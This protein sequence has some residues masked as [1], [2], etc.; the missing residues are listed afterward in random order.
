MI[1]RLKT[2]R[3]RFALWVAGLLLVA[4]SAF[5]AY[6]YGSVANGL[7]A[8]MDASL[9]IDA[10]RVADG[11]DTVPNGTY[12]L[13]ERFMQQPGNAAWLE[14][15]FTIRILSPDGL[16]LQAFGP[17]ST[18]PTPP[19]S[20]GATP[21]FATVID[22]ST[23]ATLRLY[24][25]PVEEINHRVAI[26]QVMQSLADAH[27]TLQ[28][29]LTTLLVAVPLLAASAGF[30][31]Y[32]LATRALASIDRMTRTARHISADD[33]SAR[34]NLPAT[35]DEVGRLSETFD[36][37][38]A[39]LDNAFRRERQFTADASHE[40]RTPLAAMQAILSVIREK[41]RTP[42][43]Y[44]RTLADLADEVNR[45]QT[46]TE[47]LL[48]LAR[49]EAGKPTALEPVDLSTLLLD[50]ADSMRPLAE[51]KALTLACHVPP[52]LSLLGDTDDL[53]RLFVSLLD[54]AVKYT[55]RGGV[56]LS[57]NKQQDDNLSIAI[58]DS[59]IGI[60]QAHLPHIFERFYRVDQSRAT[61]GVGLGLALA[62]EIARAHGGDITAS[63]G[64]AGGTRFTVLLSQAQSLRNVP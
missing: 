58:T 59:G 12:G 30:S 28:R 47:T 36:A 64:E 54:N 22:P 26:V 34:L 20:L 29:L 1:K 7:F 15:G 42:E 55:E 49:T 32:F 23:H 6:V 56:T 24:S 8:E 33:L 13:A 14:P 2:L 60:L 40:L 46:L 51:A 9:Q 5:G 19:A 31:G 25:F 52:G 41:R 17:Y 10:A 57:A 43:D 50:V 45:L 3:V 27:S 21:A 63:A 37:M 48:Q 44:E 4:L 39:R 38:L 16:T 18:A 62:L 61:R 11:L 53:I 35:D